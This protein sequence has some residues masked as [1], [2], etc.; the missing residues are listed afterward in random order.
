VL[1]LCNKVPYPANDGSSIAMR[2]IAEALRLNETQVHILALNTKKHHRH[3]K[4]IE[5]HKP[6]NI[7]LEHFEVDTDVK[8]TTALA[9]L[10]TTKPYHVSRFYQKSLAE[11]LQKL[12]SQ[13]KF[14]IIQLEGLSMAVYLPLIRKCSKA[15]VVIRGHN[16]EYQIWQRHIAH[17]E[18][19][20][21]RLY[22]KIQNRRLEK[23]EKQSLEAADANVFISPQ[24]QALYRN[25]GG[26]SINT[27]VPC[28]LS[29]EEH[30]PISGFQAKY[31]LVHLASF[32]WLPNKQGAAWF[33]KEVWPLILEARPNTTLGLGGRDM[34]KEFLEQS[35]DQ[36]WLYPI[37]EDARDFLAHG[38]IALVPLLAGSGMRIK[39]L[40]L[41]AWGMPT[42]ST[43]IGAE[44][45]P[46]SNY[47]EGILADD[48]EGFAAAV[49]YLLDGTEARKEM[50]MKARSFFEEK[51]DNRRLG[52]D[53]LSFYQTLI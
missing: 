21:K 42:V 5:K 10:F 50:Q 19:W 31:D 34:P 23:F 24:D 7:V 33:L 38:K 14:D 4:Q 15:S 22:L 28:G 2:S 6:D 40:E 12:L 29:K 39:L 48:P 51:F 32:D 1:I 44:G 27:V 53:L 18:N 11:R 16:I 52:K 20:L 26:R 36:L 45:I 49:I 35:N 3:G 17:E 8:V 41:L 37:V 47:Q 9:N 13:V 43:T 25:W 46:I 30:P